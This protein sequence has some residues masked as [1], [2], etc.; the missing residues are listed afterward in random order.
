MREYKYHVVVQYSCSL[1]EKGDVVSRH[2]TYENAVKASRRSG[3][4]SFLKIE[5]RIEKETTFNNSKRGAK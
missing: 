2:N 4:D 5:S 3:W 1:G